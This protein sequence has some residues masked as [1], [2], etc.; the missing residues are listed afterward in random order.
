VSKLALMD[1]QVLG[2][3]AAA[4][5]QRIL[6][7]RSTDPRFEEAMRV[8]TT[9]FIGQVNAG[10]KWSPALAGKARC[11]LRRTGA[12]SYLMTLA[13]RESRLLSF[14]TFCPGAY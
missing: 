1:S 14:S 3:S 4:D 13:F 7:N 10:G 5:T 9:V 6:Q 12:L 8:V 2:L 11:I